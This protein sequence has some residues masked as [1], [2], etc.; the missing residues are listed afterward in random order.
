[1]KQGR[2]KPPEKRQS[3]LNGKTTVGRALSLHPKAA[4]VFQKYG[5]SCTTCGGAHAEPIEKAAEIYGVD[6]RKIVR[7]LNKLLGST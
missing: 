2:A 7:D 1:M 5:M 6:S 4:S 3:R